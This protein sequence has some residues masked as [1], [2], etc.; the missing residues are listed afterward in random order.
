MAIKKKS[1][2]KKKLSDNSRDELIY[3]VMESSK[4]V[5]ECC[6]A[7][8]SHALDS[9]DINIYATCM[10]SCMD[11]DVVADMILFMLSNNS[12]NTKHALTFALHV[13][14]TTQKECKIHKN[15]NYCE[16]TCKI[17]IDAFAQYKN[18]LT[19]LRSEL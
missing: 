3:S 6:R 19:K 16:S 11:L 10:R 8:N 14:T 9:N 7:F 5:R 2:P 12:P 1:R 15:K 17:C 13:V 4:Y 18:V